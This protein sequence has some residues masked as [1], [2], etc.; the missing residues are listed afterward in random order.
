MEDSEEETEDEAKIM[1][2]TK[3]KNSFQ[4]LSLRNLIR[5]EFKLPTQLLKDNKKT[6]KK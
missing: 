2:F 3:K 1:M 4:V 5:K 6:K